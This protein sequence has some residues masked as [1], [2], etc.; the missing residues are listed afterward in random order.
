[1]S[2]KHTPRNLIQQYADNVA[3][4]KSTHP[5]R[6]RRP[7]SQ[8]PTYG[9][10]S[11]SASA[12]KRQRTA[13][14]E[15]LTPRHL[16]QG[17]IDTQDTAV[18]STRK[19]KRVG[20]L[21]PP[22]STKVKKSRRRSSLGIPSM[23]KVVNEFTP[24]T[25][26]KGFLDQ[27]LEQTPEVRVAKGDKSVARSSV[28]DLPNNEV[29]FQ[30]IEASFHENKLTKQARKSRG[31]RQRLPINI[32]RRRSEKLA[33]QQQ[34]GKELEFSS[35]EEEEYSAEEQTMEI[36]RE[37]N[38]SRRKSAHRSLHDVSDTSAKDDTSASESPR[39]SLSHSRVTP[40]KRQS[41][42]SLK[43]V[44]GVT[45]SKSL[46]MSRADAHLSPDSSVKTRTPKETRSPRRG[47][48][49]SNRRSGSMSVSP[50]STVSD[51]KVK[52]A[53]AMEQ[54]GGDMIADV[55]ED[56]D[57]E[58]SSV[59]REKSASKSKSRI[60]DDEELGSDHEQSQN[61]SKSRRDS[62]LD[63]TSSRHDEGSRPDSRANLSR[64]RSRSRVEDQGHSSPSRGDSRLGSEKKSR[65]SVKDRPSPKSRSMSK[66]KLAE[67][68]DNEDEENDDDL[69]SHMTKSTGYIPYDFPEDEPRS[70]RSSPRH[71]S[72]LVDNVYDFHDDSPSKKIIGK[73]VQTLQ[74]SASADKGDRGPSVRDDLSDQEDE[75]H[76]AREHQHTGNYSEEEQSDDDDD[77]FHG[78]PEE[79]IIPAADGETREYYTP[80]R[81]PHLKKKLSSRK[82][83]PV[84]TSTP[85]PPSVQQGEKAAK[86]KGRKKSAQQ[87]K[88]SNSYMPTS[89]VKGLFSHF[90]P[91]KVSKDAIAEVEKASAQFWEN[92]AK[93]L[94]SYALHAHRKTI[95]ES[96]VELLMKRQKFVTP[97]ESLYCLVEK[98]LPLELRQEIIPISRSGNKI[99]LK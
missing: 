25:M 80:L 59:I 83:L 9:S 29:S 11:K 31:G 50:R 36:G 14:E 82:R 46:S 73:L 67:G 17:F 71:T 34:T 68:S 4:E 16:I 30:P 66:S 10:S 21:P 63:S 27:G 70:G 65:L 94:E 72:G 86:Q 24:R 38:R 57:S 54:G 62:L 93:D 1:M 96:D 79:S 81:T 5:T 22:S 98:Y 45:P 49:R 89:V 12:S 42:A 87:K 92:A 95:E 55:E 43:N 84:V 47:T 99:E 40:S 23:D 69:S 44:S 18:P 61:K 78:E 90:C 28:G 58:G 77:S 88:L 53:H 15:D 35:E 7:V 39:K 37:A 32:V 51:Y 20:E 6:K 8:S 13:T 91:A 60:D 33:K 26:I 48:P 2:S 56:V 52:S 85:K 97:K 75:S 74:Q 19:S 3:T 41:M 76:S 64:S